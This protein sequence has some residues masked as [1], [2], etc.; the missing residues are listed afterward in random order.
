M[1]IALVLEKIVTATVQS[2]GDL[3]LALH[4]RDSASNPG[5]TGNNPSDNTAQDVSVDSS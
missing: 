5:I 4:D 1:C 2:I 3:M